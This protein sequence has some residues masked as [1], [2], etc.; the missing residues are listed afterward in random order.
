MTTKSLG[1]TVIVSLTDCCVCAGPIALTDSQERVLR[2]NHNTFY[3]PMGH[4]NYW[5][6][7]SDRERVKELEQEVQSQREYAQRVERDLGFERRSHTATKGQLT[8]T[9]KRI[10]N[11]VCPHCNRTFQNV[12]RHME[13][14][15]KDVPA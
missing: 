12:A 2:N 8:K 10:A 7:K 1:M 11:G 3:C 4:Q 9:R 14:K 15:H 13:S 5:A 6:A